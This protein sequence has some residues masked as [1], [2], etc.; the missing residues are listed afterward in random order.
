MLQDHIWYYTL[1]QEHY[2]YMLLDAFQIWFWSIF[3]L[4]YSSRLLM[5]QDHKVLVVQD[6][7]GRGQNVKEANQG[8]NIETA[9]TQ[10]Y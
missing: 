6:H 7:I 4:E 1:L 2:C 5:I 9:M 3:H 10:Y 8:L